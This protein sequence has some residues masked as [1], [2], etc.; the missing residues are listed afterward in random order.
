VS[1][2]WNIL[3]LVH[4][5]QTDEHKMYALVYRERDGDFLYGLSQ[6]HNKGYPIVISIAYVDFPRSSDSSR[7][8]A[9]RI[10]FVTTRCCNY[11]LFELLMMGE[12]FTRNM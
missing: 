10:L 8:T 9:R 6:Y 12:C 1:Y 5:A 11:S 2:R 4:E 7:T 3:E